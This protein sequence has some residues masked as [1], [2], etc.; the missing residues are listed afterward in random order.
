MLAVVGLSW[1]L[2]QLPGAALV[3]GDDRAHVL[4]A[5]G[6]VDQRGDVDAPHALHAVE[7]RKGLVGKV[8]VG[9]SKMEIGPCPQV[10]GC[11]ELSGKG[12]AW[13]QHSL[14]SGMLVDVLVPVR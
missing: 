8:P 4:L 7:I 2:E 1:G 12:N 3:E 9:V 10:W 13:I 14:K 6:A 5:E 11:G